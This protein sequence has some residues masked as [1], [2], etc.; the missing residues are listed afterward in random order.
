MW[1]AEEYRRWFLESD[2]IKRWGG[3]P[4]HTMSKR[5]KKEEPQED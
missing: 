4:L 2:I 3:L 5:I 1:E